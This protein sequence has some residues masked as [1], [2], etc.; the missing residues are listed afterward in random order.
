MLGLSVVLGLARQNMTS[1][2]IRCPVVDTIVTHLDTLYGH[3]GTSRTLPQFCSLQ[4][5]GELSR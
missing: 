2:V 3:W 5:M 1:P 4:L